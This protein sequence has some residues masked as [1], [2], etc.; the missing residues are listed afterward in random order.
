MKKHII[1]VLVLVIAN[2]AFAQIT[3]FACPDSFTSLPNVY[4][5][6]LEGTDATGR[7]YYQTNPIDGSQPCS[8]GACEFRIAWNAG[9]NRW[10]ILLVQ[11]QIDFS[12]A[13]VVYFNTSASTPNPP[14]LNLGSWVIDDTESNCDAVL[15][16]G[17]STL[18]GNVQDGIT[19]GIDDLESLNNNISIYPNPA[20]QTI[21]VRSGA[22]PVKE[23]SLYSL[24]GR[25]V[26]K[27]LNSDKLDVSKLS[28]GIYLLQVTTY[29]SKTLKRKIVIN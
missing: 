16:N 14:S 6:A 23:I 8:A 28:K 10:E 9:L 12:D 13:T 20:S 1:V 5:F 27:D 18:S 17:N 22:E 4:T 7:N 3:F 19:L 11:N 26:L 25:Q 21:F 24:L 2:V 15:T 29:S